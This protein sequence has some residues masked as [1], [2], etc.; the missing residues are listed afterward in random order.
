MLRTLK[1]GGLP[2]LLAFVFLFAAFGLLPK[3]TF[4]AAT[5]P[6][7]SCTDTISD[8]ANLFGNQTAAVLQQA[9][10][11]NTSLG[12]DT[13]V[14]TVTPEKLA[15]RSL[16]SYFRSILGN[17]P[18]W[19][20][21]NFAVFILTKGS[22]PFLH[23]GS[24]FDGKL[25]TADFQQATLSVKTKLQNGDYAQATIDLIQQ[26]N[27]KLSP[28]Y[29]GLLITIGVVVLL[30]AAAILAFVIVRR[31]SAIAVVTS[32]RG[33]AISAKQAA[34]NAVSPLNTQIGELSPRIEVLLALI[35]QATATQL[36]GLFETA[37]GQ[38]NSVQE[39]LSNLL[40]N[41]STNPNDS[42]LLSEQQYAQMHIAYQSV[43]NESQEPQQ[44]LHVLE[45][46]VQTLE[47]N[48]QQQIDFQHL[49][50]R[51]IH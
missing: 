3:H 36:H 16:S 37:Q 26:V 34:V 38:A 12:A 23:L 40:G 27:K 13:R 22:E 35:P 21:A 17:C 30:L 6:L 32:A 28:N 49:T 5:T 9:Q 43:Y 2:I 1:L 48:P 10:A 8:D 45:S 7:G 4:A 39:K 47:S 14:V 42:T 50:M 33:N 15:G 20:G 11:M 51:Q 24:K 19:N 41:P 44:L 25:T 46:A 31:R 18:T 29:T